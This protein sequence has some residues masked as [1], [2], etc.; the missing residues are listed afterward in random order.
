MRTYSLLLATSVALVGPVQADAQSIGPLPDTA[1]SQKV[2][3]S[4]PQLMKLARSMAARGERTEAKS[5]FSLLA[6]DPSAEVRTEAR[7]GLANILE[8]EGQLKAAALLY[9]RIL[10]DKPEAA[11]VRFRLARLLQGMGQTDS[12]LRELRALRSANLPKAAARFLDR[13]SASLQATKP[14]GFQFEMAFAPDSNVNRATNADTLGT[15]LGDFAIDDQSKAKSGVGLALRG[16]GQSRI[17]VAPNLFLVTRLS[18]ES[19][20][21]RHTA[22]DLTSLQLAVGPEWKLGSLRLS[23]EAGAAVHWFGMK[24]FE[25]DLHLSASGTHPLSATSQLRGDVSHSW[26]DNRLNK[27]QSG[28]GSTLAA[29]YEMFLSPQLSVGA[30]A[31]VGRFKAR[32]AA[33]STRSWT[34]GISIARDIG[35]TTFNVAA[36]IGRLKADDRLQILPEARRDRS[37]RLSLGAVFRQLTVRGFA[38]VARL[39]IERNRSNVAFYDYRRIRQEFGISRAF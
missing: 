33:Y 3:A 12:A 16:L 9:R 11:A 39:V 27:L 28:Q 8:L 4:A 31:G 1:R 18:R 29:G 15:L 26:S 21:Y 24:P 5:L 37:A 6:R 13:L 38:P 7:F 30:S 17:S 35:R 34:A 23:A 20:L 2:V 36:E 19:N 14:L 25:R 22:F 10:D 32:D